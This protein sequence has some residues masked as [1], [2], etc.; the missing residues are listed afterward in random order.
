MRPW[1][2]TIALNPPQNIR[3]P[4]NGNVFGSMYFF[5]RG[6]LMNFAPILSR[7]RRDL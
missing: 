7:S 2:D 3:F 6:S 1:S 5:I 4:S